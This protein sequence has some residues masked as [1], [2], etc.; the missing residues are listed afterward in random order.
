MFKTKCG[1]RSNTFSTKKQF[2]GKTCY[3]LPILLRL[4]NVGH[5]FCNKT[6]PEII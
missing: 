2:T 1:H 5:S 6:M 4:S 3:F